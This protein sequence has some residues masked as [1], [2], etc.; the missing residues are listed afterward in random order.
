MSE[1]VTASD[2]RANLEAVRERIGA[3][4]AR[5][6]RNPATVALVAVAKTHGPAAI[7]AA[8]AAG[9]RLFAENRVQEAKAKWPEIKARHPD[10]ALHL[11][12]A[13]QTNKSLDAV[14]LFD[15]IESLDRPRLA[16]ALAKVMDAEGRRPRC[17]IQVNTGEE[18][19]KAGVAPAEADRFIAE[20]R[21]R[22]KLPVAGLMCIPPLGEEPSL[23]FALL[24]EIARRNGLAELSMGMSHDFEIAIEM[25]ATEARIGTA[26]FGERSTTPETSN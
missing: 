21:E 18:P 9:Q 4:A 16:E 11:I 26:I 15:A 3:A 22:W 5:A 17:L 10:I 7:A 6:G 14:R 13:L 23:H 8:I 25:G 2:I 19:Q 12:G 1:A 24:R 20:T